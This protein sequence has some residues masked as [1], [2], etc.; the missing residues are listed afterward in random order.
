MRSIYHIRE[1]SVRRLSLVRS[2]QI[3][4]FRC[5]TLLQ[6]PSTQIFLS[7]DWPQSVEHYGDLNDLL[8]RKTFLKDDIAKGTLGSPPL[9]GLLRTLRPEWWFSAHLHTRYQASIFHNP[10]SLNAVVAQNPDE[11]IIKDD[12]FQTNLGHAELDEPDAIKLI[13]EEQTAD[14]RTT[15]PQHAQTTFLALDKCLPKRQFLEVYQ[16]NHSVFML[17]Y[18]PTG[19][20]SR[21]SNRTTM[22]GR[23]QI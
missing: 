13:K 18:P 17:S 20:R 11:V 1:Y 5:L 9:M 8:R 6:L 7:H 14:A 4:A 19:S 16:Q 22:L 3:S 2:L 21:N 15:G 23:W 12:E 10:P